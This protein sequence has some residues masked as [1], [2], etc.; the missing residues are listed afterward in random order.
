LIPLKD[1]YRDNLLV[2][3]DAS[4]HFV[5]RQNFGSGISS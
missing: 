2:E 3:I 4:D 5:P 1:A